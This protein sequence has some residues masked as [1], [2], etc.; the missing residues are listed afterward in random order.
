MEKTKIICKNQK[1]LVEFIQNFIVKNELKQNYIIAETENF[2]FKYKIFNGQLTLFSQ[3]ETY[4]EQ[5]PKLNSDTWNNQELEFKLK[6]KPLP[7]NIK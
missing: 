3:Y 7:K 4:W 2:W 1:E 5:R 6:I